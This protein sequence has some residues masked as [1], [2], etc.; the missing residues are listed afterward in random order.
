MGSKNPFKDSQQS[1]FLTKKLLPWALYSLVPIIFIRLYLYPIP[2]A[3]SRFS[4]EDFQATPIISS[5]SSENDFQASPNPVQTSQQDFQTTP[6]VSNPSETRNEDFQATPIITTNI[7]ETASQEVL[8]TIPTSNA[9][10]TS[11]GDIQTKPIGSNSSQEDRQVTPITTTSFNITETIQEAF[12]AAP[13][14]TTSSNI[15]ETIQEERLITNESPCDYFNG[16]WVQ[17]KL[18]PLYN[19]TTCSTIK[20][21]QN[22]ISHGR[23]DFGFLYWRWEPKQCK[24]PRFN[25]TTFLELHKNKHIAFIGDSMARNQMESLLCLLSTVSLPD[26]VYTSGEDNKFRRW[27]LPSHNINVSIYWSPFLVKGIEKNA[28]FNYNKLFFDSV[29]EKWAN[30]MD[31]FD[32]IVLSIG[33]WFLHP[34]VYYDKE[35]LLGC[36][37]CPDLNYTQIGFYDVFRKAFNTTLKAITDR[38][39]NNAVDVIL[40]TFSPAHFEGEWD[41][42]GACPKKEPLKEGEKNLEWMDAEMRKIGVEEIEK[43]KENAAGLTKL[44]FQA[45]D[46]TS[47]SNMRP[48]SHP[49]PYMNPFPFANGVTDRVQN[50]CVHWCLPGAIDT[51]NEI[52]LEVIKRWE[53]QSSRVS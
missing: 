13:I 3:Q 45:L 2:L 52:M 10:Q 9:S 16:K 44:R 31:Q 48:D 22:C 51:W 43:A 12:Q 34:A 25:S 27:N 36:H 47:L 24:L 38:R 8:P 39:G 6:I 20:D 46:V 29:D 19:G 7:S 42:A 33:H 40:T 26:L 28:E 17:D 15:T 1:H 21:G 37:Y 41:K 32:V 50:D 14:T 18:G 49:G 5:T 35:V 4:Q 23:P 30:D 53:G 11:Q